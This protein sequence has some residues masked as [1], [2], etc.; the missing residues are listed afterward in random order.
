MNLKKIFQRIVL[1]SGIVFVSCAVF[2]VEAFAEQTIPGQS[3]LQEIIENQGETIV[4]GGDGTTPG[5][6]VPQTVVD[7]GYSGK[8]DATTGEAVVGNIVSSIDNYYVLKKDELAFNADKQQY[9]I[10]CGDR[11]VYCNMPSNA[12]LTNGDSLKF[13]FDEGVSCEIYLNGD[14]V[15]DSSQR[16]FYESGEYLLMMRNHA[17]SKERNVR[18]IIADQVTGSIKEYRL[19]D[20]FEYTDVRLDGVK[21][22]VEYNNYYDFLEDGFYQLKWENSRIN[23]TFVTEFILDLTPPKLELPE[24]RN[25]AATGQVSFTDMEADEYVR[26]IR[27]SKEEGR[28]E[29]PSEVLTKKGNYRLR[30]YDEAGNYTEY[31]FAI[32]GYFDVN[33]VLALLL[34][35][36]IIGGGFLYCRRLRTHMRVG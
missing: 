9:H 7:I 10:L 1:L 32:E 13:T 8:I 11:G 22:S 29:D 5:S 36:A 12:V 14:P 4:I 33:A 23:Q 16:E 18:F 25:G 28:I 35:L 26:W 2:S 20:G 6:S 27:D 31:T 3:A 24:V 15:E 19:P 34:V 21:K 30:V 17:Q